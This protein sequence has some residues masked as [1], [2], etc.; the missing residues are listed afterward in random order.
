MTAAPSAVRVSTTTERLPRL[1]PLKIA[2]MPLRR[3]PIMRARSPTPSGSSILITS[4]PCSARTMPAKG[5]DT[6]WAAST[7]RTPA[8]G[9]IVRSLAQRSRPCRVCCRTLADGARSRSA[10][11]DD[12]RRPASATDDRWARGQPSRS[13]TTSIQSWVVSASDSTSM[14]SSLPW[15]RRREVGGGERRRAQAGAVG[16]GPE[17]A[18]DAGVGEPDGEL[19]A[20]RRRRKRPGHRTLQAVP[21]RRVGGAHRGPVVHQ[22]LD[23][24]VVGEVAERGAQMGGDLVGALAGHGAD[25]DVEMHGVGDDVGLGLAHR[26]VGRERRVRAGVEVTGAGRRRAGRRAGRRSGRDRPARRGCRRRARATSTSLRQ[27]SWNAGAGR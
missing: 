26:D 7:T 23:L 27:C 5:A 6:I 2:L 19:G 17:V 20:E 25:V 12:A 21:Q 22:R 4:A 14:R 1:T 15:N 24:D 18:V 3:L 11:Q 8:S 13:V 10:A 16:D 9:S